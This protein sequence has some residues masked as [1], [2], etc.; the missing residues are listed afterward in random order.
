M[1][2]VSW[3]H[4][5]WQDF[6]VGDMLLNHCLQ[7]LTSLCHTLKPLP[8]PWGRATGD[9]KTVLSLCTGV[10]WVVSSMWN[11]EGTQLPTSFAYACLRVLTLTCRVWNMYSLTCR[12]W[13]RLT[14]HACTASGHWWLITEKCPGSPEANISTTWPVQYLCR[15]DSYSPSFQSKLHKQIAH[16]ASMPISVVAFWM[17]LLWVTSLAAPPCSPLCRFGT[18]CW[19]AQQC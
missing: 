3:P 16:M 18:I 19:W 8:V 15:T 13:R 12:V 5:R 6:H 2:K 4:R 1:L 11:Q 7:N 9:I 17:L 10:G 14:W